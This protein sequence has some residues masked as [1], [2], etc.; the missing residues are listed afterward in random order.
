MKFVEQR[1]ATMKK[2]VLYLFGLLFGLPCVLPGALPPDVM[3]ARFKDDCAAAVSLTFDDATRSHVET[4]IPVLDRYGLKGTFFLLCSNIHPDGASTWEAWRR[5]VANGHEAGSHSL[6]HPLLTKVQDM[7]RVLSEIEGSADLIEA[8]VGV[9]PVAFAYPESDFNDFVKKTVLDVY[10]FDRADCRVWGGAG[11]SEKSGIRH[12]E[13]A[14]ENNEWFYCM[15]H[16]V[17]ED[18]W[19][20]LDPDILDGLARYLVAHRDR[21][22]TDTYSRVN[23]YVRKRNA[24]DINL[25]NVRPDRFEFRLSLPDESIYKRLLPVPL[26][27]KIALEGRDGSR[28]S[29]SLDGK[30]LSLRP[31]GCGHY[32]LVDLQADGRWVDVSW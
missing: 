10:V 1:G 21:L 4:A 20:A 26:T 15:L 12:L 6:T 23:S 3:I 25:R 18:T 17:G 29:A 8:K 24:A 22:W 14:V 27:V 16:G 7:S 13:Q 5:A 30:P 9:R 31:S 11:F 2:M 28:V 32:V 19:G